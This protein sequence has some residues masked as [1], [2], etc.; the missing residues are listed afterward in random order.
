MA[1]SI[2]DYFAA[3]ALQGFI[4][5]GVYKDLG[6]GGKRVSILSYQIADE[7]LEARNEE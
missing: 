5:R 3:A 7:M 2:R 6:D 4:S 1:V